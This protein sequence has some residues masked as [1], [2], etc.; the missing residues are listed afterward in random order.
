MLFRSARKVTGDFV[1]KLN[2]RFWD[3]FTQ[4][5]YFLVIKISYVR[6]D[7]IGISAKTATRKVTLALHRVA[8][9]KTPNN[10]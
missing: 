7:L 8:L 2:K 5:I 10:A 9:K 3:T 6:G 4:N 1:F